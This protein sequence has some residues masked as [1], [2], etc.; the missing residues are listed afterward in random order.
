M[1][2]SKSFFLAPNWLK[3]SVLTLTVIW[4]AFSSRAKLYFLFNA[5]IKRS[6][7]YYKIF[8][9]RSYGQLLVLLSFSCFYISNEQKHL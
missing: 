7:W 2:N 5:L 8:T 6:W 3:I 4:Y 1:V 9:L